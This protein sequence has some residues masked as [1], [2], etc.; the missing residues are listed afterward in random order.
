MV[1][2]D[3]QWVSPMAPG[4]RP[5]ELP[6]FHKLD[7]YVF[8][9]LCRDLFDAESDISTC[10]VYGVRGQS[11]DGIDLIAYR[12]DGS[13]IEVGQC[14]CYESFTQNKIR[15][16]SDD[17]FIHWDSHW[18]KEKV[19]KFIL[20]AACDLS[21]TKQQNEIVE[22]RKRFAKYD[23]VYEAWSAATIQ[24]KL[25]PRPG[26]VS[27]YLTPADH[28]VRT[29]CGTVAAQPSPGGQ[30]GEQMSIRVSTALTN[31][32]EQL[33][34]QLSKETEQRLEYMRAEYR[35]GRYLEVIK[36]LRELKSNNTRWSALS[37]NTKAKLLNFEAGLELQ[38]SNDIRRATELADEAQ[39]LA[40]L[41]NQTRLRAYL[42]WREE[43]P[44]AA[45]KLLEGQNDVDSL[46]LKGIV[47][48][49]LGR[50]DECLTLLTLQNHEREVN[51][52]T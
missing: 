28:W 8:Q 7:E 31:Q 43:G 26:I 9:D 19:E 29:I 50:I 40:P 3:R 34:A 41:E 1:E 12:A 46:N 10:E 45:L 32:L 20:F 42:A 33:S 48:L 18:S 4:V 16:A 39:A 6:P 44:E 49:N 47:L 36:W 27:T 23:I 22:Q 52:K 15:K 38:A 30:Q 5:G 13:G 35:E 24:N 2:Q 37:A 11:Q 21:R 14:K 51:D 17:F 25:R